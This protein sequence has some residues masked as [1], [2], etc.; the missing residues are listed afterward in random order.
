MLS[1]FSDGCL[2]KGTF[3]SAGRRWDDGCDYTC[4]C[5]DPKTGQYKCTPKY[6][7]YVYV[8]FTSGPFSR[9]KSKSQTAVLRLVNDYHE[10]IAEELQHYV[11]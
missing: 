6:V 8:L 2:Y 4:V 1:R 5:E 3:Y 10:E 11:C 9:V 7:L